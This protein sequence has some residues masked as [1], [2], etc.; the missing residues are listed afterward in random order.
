YNG[1]RTRSKAK[2]KTHSAHD[3]AGQRLARTHYIRMT[4]PKHKPNKRGM[5]RTYIGR[6]PKSRLAIEN[7]PQYAGPRKDLEIKRETN[8]K[9]NKAQAAKK[10]HIAN[11]I[12]H[13]KIKS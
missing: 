9:L 13:Q 11:G 10:T 4:R 6:A 1:K 3:T 5:R 2:I 7:A 8:A 12:A